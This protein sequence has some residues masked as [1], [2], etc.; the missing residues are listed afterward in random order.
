MSDT[1]IRVENIS[2]LY[3]LGEVGTGSLAHDV[4]RWWHRVRGKE[5]PY[6]KI[7]EVNDRTKPV[8]GSKKRSLTTEDTE[9]TEGA[10]GVRLGGQ[11]GAAFSNP[12]TSGLARD[13]E[14]TSLIRSANAPRS[15]GQ[16]NGLRDDAERNPAENFKLK[17]ENSA[18]P[19][20]DWVYALKDV[21][22]EV[23]RGEVLGIIGRNGAG[24]STLLKI[25]SRVTTQSSGQIKVKGRI[26]SLLEVGTGFHPELTGPGEVSFALHWPRRETEGWAAWSK[27]NRRLARRVKRRRGGANQNIFLNGAI[28][29]MRKAEIARKFDEIVEFSG[30]ARYIDTPVKRYSSGMYVR[31]AAF[32]VAAHLEPEPRRR[33]HRDRLPQAG[34]Q[35]FAIW[36]KRK[37]NFD[38]GLGLGGGRCGIPKKA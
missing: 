24:K 20:S 12:S 31:L 32:A 8:S 34:P 1:V 22:F 17:T 23:K 35:G 37:P 21:S 16:K 3:R 36:E 26:A 2:K 15:A 6:L 11:A 25:L 4:N 33:A 7:G 14:N 5:D 27:S 13:S 9:S 10:A 18:P 28:L 38:H 30:C 29:G 19:A